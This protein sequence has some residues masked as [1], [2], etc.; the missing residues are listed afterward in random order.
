MPK[1]R[2]FTGTASPCASVIVLFSEL[3]SITLSDKGEAGLVTLG[4]GFDSDVVL[5]VSMCA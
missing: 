5:V 2:V 4:A 1:L 3:A